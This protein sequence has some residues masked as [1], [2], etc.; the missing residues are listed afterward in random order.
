MVKPTLAVRHTLEN[1]LAIAQKRFEDAARRA[2]GNPDE[3][4]YVV[5][6]GARLKE[7]D[8]IVAAIAKTGRCMNVGRPP[9]PFL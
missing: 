2:V 7:R 5:A 6:L 9:N 1:E 8:E 4:V 3:R